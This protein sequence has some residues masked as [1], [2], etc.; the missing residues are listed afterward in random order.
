MHN[1]G[2]IFETSILSSRNCFKLLVKMISA[3]P[4]AGCP[5]FKFFTMQ[6]QPSASCARMWTVLSATIMFADKPHVVQVFG[7]RDADTIHA[8]LQPAS[9]KRQGTKSREVCGQRVPRALWGFCR[10]FGLVEVGLKRSPR[11]ACG[12]PWWHASV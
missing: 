6:M 4:I 3:S 2:V 11:S 1:F 12:E 5:S 9:K 10:R 7:R 8:L